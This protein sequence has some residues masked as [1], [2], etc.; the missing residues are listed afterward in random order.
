MN[1]LEFISI[2]QTFCVRLVQI[3]VHFLWQGTLLAALSGAMA[4]ALRRASARA[5]YA[6]FLVTLLLMAC[7]LPA[8]YVALGGRQPNPAGPSAATVPV[9]MSALRDAG[10]SRVLR[11]GTPPTGASKVID[12]FSPVPAQNDGT[13]T[14]FEA[15]AV[16]GEK[17]P[18]LSR[19]LNWQRY[20]SHGVLAYLCGVFVM[21][22]RLVLGLY[23]GG[24]LRRRSEPVEDAA[25]LETVARHAKLFGLRLAPAVAYCGRVAVPTVVGVL[26][27]MILLPASLASG[28]TPKQLELLLSHELAHIRRYDHLV[29]ILQRLIEALLFFHAA[30]WYVSH[31]I[32]I[33]REHCC[34]DLVVAQ[35][36]EARAYVESLV[37]AAAFAGS[38]HGAPSLGA[39]RAA[40]RPS[41]LR[42]RIH[43]LLG[44]GGP[45]VRLA[46]G[47]WL[48]ALALVA[49]LFLGAQQLVATGAEPTGAPRDAATSVQETGATM[50]DLGA[51]P[52]PALG[53]A[54]KKQAP[55]LVAEG[56][57]EEYE[58]VLKG[59]EALA[60]ENGD[61]T[62]HRTVIELAVWGMKARITEA[63]FGESVVVEDIRDIT[64]KPGATIDATV[65]LE[66]KN[67]CP[68]N[69]IFPL[70]GTATWGDPQS[71]WWLVEGWVRQGVR[72]VETHVRLR[73]PGKPGIYHIIFAGTA[74]MDGEEIMSA[75]YRT[76]ESP[77]PI[78]NDG[79]D[80]A[81]WP[82][83]LVQEAM[84]D[85][86]AWAPWFTRD[87]RRDNEVAADAIRV[88]V[89][90][91]EA[92][93]VP[94]RDEAGADQ[95]LMRN[96][97]R[98]S[99]RILNKTFAIRTP[100]VRLG[101]E[102]DRIVRILFDAPDAGQASIYLEAGR[103]LVGVLDEETIRLKLL[104]GSAVTLDT[105][106]VKE[107]RIAVVPSTSAEIE[108][109]QTSPYPLPPRQDITFPDAPPTLEMDV[110]GNW[111]GPGRRGLALPVTE[112]VPDAPPALEM[113][114][115]GNWTGG[116]QLRPARRRGL[117]LPVTEAVYE[118]W[119]GTGLWLVKGDVLYIE[120][121]G[122]IKWSTDPTEPACGPDGMGNSNPDSVIPNVSGGAL[123]GRVGLELLDDGVDSSGRGVYGPG[124]VGSRFKWAK[125]SDGPGELQLMFHDSVHGDNSGSFHAR[126]WI[127][128]PDGTGVPPRSTFS[129]PVPGGADFGDELPE[130]VR[131]STR[132]AMDL[133][134]ML[135]KDGENLFFSPCSI[136]T[137][138][139]MAYAGAQGETRAQMQ[140]VLGFPAEDKEVHAF[141]S[142][143]HQRLNQNGD[144]RVSMANRLWGQVDYPFR[145]TFLDLTR[146]DYGA[147][148]AQVDFVHTAERE[149]ARQRIN[150]WIAER[151]EYKI[152]NLLAPG[153]LNEF[154]V[155]VLTNAIY[156]KG[157]W[158]NPFKESA[159]REEPF[160]V[161]PGT[162]PAVPMMHRTTEVGYCEAPDYQVVDIPYKGEEFSMV[163]VLPRE[164]FGLAA[165]ER[166]ATELD[167]YA[168]PGLLQPTRV[169][170]YLPRF[171]LEE[172][173]DLVEALKTMGMTDAFELG[174]AD[175][176]GMLMRTR[177]DP[178]FIS[179][180]IHKARIDVDETGTEAAAATAVIVPPSVAMPSSEARPVVFRADHPFLLLIRDTRSGTILFAG[181]VA[182]PA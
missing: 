13:E 157:D 129:S 34:D 178:L 27:P 8:T 137:A 164:R 111:T 9:A 167:L 75:S 68:N 6:V 4:F 134:G 159:T 14:K 26:R 125:R 92:E 100:Q 20:A 83:S 151:T 82:Q 46:R 166:S 122:R 73:A 174:V 98:I 141:Y 80:I 31:R 112:A 15:Q 76:Q 123:I 101:L 177:R 55:A 97:D 120:T 126:I 60:P 152:E 70:A 78:W 99:G 47:G 10:A 3:L 86:S 142:G 139:A 64:V 121:S 18:L 87:G 127:V 43:R 63:E 117:V 61:E 124:F 5:R 180:V 90:G 114:V 155:L 12:E 176:S 94:G 165:L 56:R 138:L 51:V 33:E 37:Q 39:L 163:V 143:L 181:R 150:T 132:F 96:G 173:F 156:F 147:E 95:I 69:W 85:G 133:Y 74:G 168:L 32:R 106:Q 44:T 25:I 36:G 84:D 48:A 91:E 40:G 161:D 42:R 29:N 2:D 104:Y 158:A 146:R 19:Q 169:E 59:P 72:K 17:T 108:N 162:T 65:W 154:T 11:P 144:V 136:S 57:L 172:K 160:F 23:G 171:A 54:L 153:V 102:R 118:P 105:A 79:N 50:V 140:R 30:V 53:D 170:I 49:V 81:R 93:T 35:G 58:A 77:Q 66:V 182:N 149:R 148:L 107:I 16:V 28:L 1:L 110:L 131:G 88:T 41:T 52:P 130:A 89:E 22:V 67:P 128:K 175:F 103:C 38:A 179:A 116:D 71:S 113:H 45:P 119:Q 135:A 145:R 109:Q 62:V 21:L 24:R 115:L 7:C